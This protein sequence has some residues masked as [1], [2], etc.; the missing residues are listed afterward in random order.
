MYIKKI[1]L[2]NFKKFESLDLDFNKDVNIFVGDNESGK[3]TILQAIDLVIRGSV[4]RIE[5]IGINRLMNSAAVEKFNSNERSYENLP[6]IVV[7]LY[8]SDDLEG[9]TGKTNSKQLYCSGI[10]LWCH[11]N[12]RFSKEIVES[13]A[14]GEAEIPYD[15]Y[16]IKF[17]KFDGNPYNRRERIV[18]S[19]FVDNS[20]IGSAYAMNEY[21]HSIF[22]ASL[23]PQKQVELKQKYR[24]HK[25][26]FVKSILKDYLLNRE[27]C[28]FSLKNSTRNNLETDLSI[29]E[30]GISL[31][32]K[33]TGAQCFIKTDLALSKN[34]NTDIVLM[35]EPENHLSYTNTLKLIEKIKASTNQLFISTHSD[36]IC[37]RLDLRKCFLLNSG[38]E[39]VTPLQRV[40]Q[41]TSDFFLKAPDN[42]MLQFVLSSK[43][44]LVEGDAE[45]I[46]MDKMFNTTIKKTLKESNIGTLSVDGLCFKRYLDIARI[47]GIKVAVITDNDKNIEENITDKYAEYI[48]DTIQI[49]A[50]TD[51][52]RY[53]FEV[54]IYGDNKQLCDKLFLPGRKKLTVQE[55][56][57]SN[58]A[59]A[60]FEL[61]KS[62]DDITVPKYIQ[63]ALLWISA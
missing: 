35:E 60:A 10:R 32:D 29:S 23:E 25:D 24:S 57:L 26:S 12:D 50:D 46:L 11:A 14:S 1:L 63:D 16:E 47:L 8:L 19:L 37:T 40:S 15:Y 7:E 53:T 5:E 4:S 13:L 42:K 51:N 27:N 21:V 18:K 43:I 58:K 9:I 36:L 54:C 3:S 6:E 31:E 30:N 44:I 39:I 55:Y 45:Y 22:E 33:G 49:F 2:K 62:A 56:M 38:S 41:D 28:S 59:D 20:N 34:E 17:E 48:S 52:N 61:A